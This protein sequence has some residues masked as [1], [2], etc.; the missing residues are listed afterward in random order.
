MGGEPF[1]ALKRALLRDP[2]CPEAEDGLESGRLPVGPT[3]TPR[4]SGRK[5]ASTC[6]CA[7][8]FQGVPQ[9]QAAPWGRGVGHRV[10]TTLPVVGGGTST[11]LWARQGEGS[12]ICSVSQST[13]EPLQQIAHKRWTIWR[14]YSHVYIQVQ[15]TADHLM[16]YAPRMYHSPRFTQ[17]H[18]SL[19]QWRMEWGLPRGWLGFPCFTSALRELDTGTD[20]H[21]ENKPKYRNMK[22]KRDSF[23]H[24]RYLATLKSL[25]IPVKWKQEPGT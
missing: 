1:V 12:L 22:I 9:P 10:C 3:A 2:G 5:R 25:E 18:L 4:A 6:L 19:E 20:R 24:I 13:Q 11:G 17:T 16:S 8:A 7:G 23:K 14:F 15:K 21:S